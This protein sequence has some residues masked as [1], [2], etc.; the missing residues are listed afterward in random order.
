MSLNILFVGLAVFLAHLLSALFRRTRIPDVLLILLLGVA[1]GPYV[2]GWVRVEDFGKAG[3]VLTT[4]ALIVILFEG[5]VGMTLRSAG[6]AILDATPLTLA[7]SLLTA[8]LVAAVALPLM[9]S[10]QSALLLGL[11]LSGTSSAV[12]IPMVAGLGAG[13]RVKGLLAMESA[14]TDVT[15]IIGFTALSV[16]MQSG[17]VS[18]SGVASGVLASLVVASVIGV[19]GAVGWLLVLGRLRSFPHT[20]SSIFAWLFILYGV[21]EALN[22]SG[23]ITALAFGVTLV[24]TP[25][26]RLAGLAGTSVGSISETERN[27]FSEVVVL[28]KLFFFIYLGLSLRLDRIEPYLVAGTA[29]GAVYLARLALARLLLPRDTSRRDAVITALMVPKGLAAAVLASA[30]AQAGLPGGEMIRDLAFAAVG[31][32]ILGTSL[33]VPLAELPGLR[34]L[35]GLPFRSFPAGSRTRP[36]SRIFGLDAGTGTALA[37]AARSAG[38]DPDLHGSP[39]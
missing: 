11:I 30:A 38:P 36:A 25:R 9:P 23:A 1:L 18:A 12:V 14:L 35:A 21:A 17:S 6:R 15:C 39:T 26:E 8:A 3:P 27:L 19:V 33:L 16:A 32:S 34:L 10:W 20:L 29:M 28:M 37:E 2:L 31:I 7:T 5:G 4:I 13:T 24:N 22:F